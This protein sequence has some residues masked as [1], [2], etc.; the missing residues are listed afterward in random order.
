MPLLHPPPHGEGSISNLQDENTG[1]PFIPYISGENAFLFSVITPIYDAIKAEVAPPLT[2]P[3]ELRRHQRVLL[4]T[5][6]LR[7]PPMAHGAQLQ[8]LHHRKD[9]LRRE[10]LVLERLPHL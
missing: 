7:P 5:P 9:G 8:F 6:L 1:R 3:A 10:E 4:E 2:P